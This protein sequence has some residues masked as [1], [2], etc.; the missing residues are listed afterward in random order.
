MLKLF[1]AKSSR[2]LCVEHT[3]EQILIKSQQTRWI[4][5]RKQPWMPRA[6]NK[7]FRVPPL[8][9]Q[10]AAEREYMTPIWNNYKANMRSMYQLFE[11]EFKFSAQESKKVQ[12]ERVRLL[13]REAVLLAENDKLNRETLEM[14]TRE[15]AVKLA[16]RIK[17][18]EIDFKKK[19]KLDELYRAEAEQQVRKMKEK[20]KSFI[21][22]NNLEYEIEKALNERV[23]YNFAVNF[24][25]QIFKN[26]V[27]VSLDKAFDGR[28]IPSPTV[29]QQR[30]LDEE[31]AA[32]AAAASD[33]S[34]TTAPV[35]QGTKNDSST[36]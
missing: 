10:D 13:E 28:F 14:Q 26:R 15:E 4:R 19:L 27:Q 25:G 11:T 35:E 9:K 5:N 2:A 8:P 18:V 30:L 31:A 6:K 32:A 3:F 16:E 23:E 21:D 17:Q 20:V 22:P 33:N 12:D 36:L 34:A 24:S 29:R 1:G 7:A